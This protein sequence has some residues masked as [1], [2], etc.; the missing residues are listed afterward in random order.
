MS[1]KAGQLQ[2]VHVLP[3]WSVSAVPILLVFPSRHDLAPAVRA[4][5]DFMVE[6]EVEAPWRRE[7]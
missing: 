1:T 4:F 5:P 7:D 6:I 3:E 2:L